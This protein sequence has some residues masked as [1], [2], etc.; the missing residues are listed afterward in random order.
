MNTT[1]RI[2]GEA[3]RPPTERELMDPWWAYRYATC[4]IKGRR[5]PEGEPA[6]A[7]D[8]ECAKWYLKQ[9]PEAKLEWAMNGRIDW[10]D[11]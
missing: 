1:S 5:W 9:F 8:P 11:L 3:V 2:L 4:V 10:L 7:K 6:I